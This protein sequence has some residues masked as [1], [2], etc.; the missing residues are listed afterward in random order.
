MKVRMLQSQYGPDVARNAG[1]EVE[2]DDAEA[3][4]LIEA[5]IAEPVR[6]AATPE[7]TVKPVKAEKAVR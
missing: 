7:T 4:R 5:S 1:D 6:S 3:K 2:V